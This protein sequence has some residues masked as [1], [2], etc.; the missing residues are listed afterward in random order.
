MKKVLA[1]SLLAALVFTPAL[2]A[3]KNAAAHPSKNTVIQ[4]GT[5]QWD[6]YS[7]IIASWAKEEKMEFIQ[8]GMNKLKSIPEV[9]CATNVPEE[10]LFKMTEKD[11]E[12]FFVA[13]YNELWEKPAGNI[14]N[15]PGNRA[16]KIERL[17]KYPFYAF[18]SDGGARTESLYDFAEKFYPEL[19]IILAQTVSAAEGI[20][21]DACTFEENGQMFTRKVINS[22]KMSSDTENRLNNKMN[23]GGFGIQDI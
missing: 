5:P 3:G 14:F 22:E 2:Y 18:L 10:E 21:L 23:S 9:S 19:Y 15:T 11:R 1:L 16:D 7:K 4:R 20:A 6:A 13:G 8:A 12:A 17:V